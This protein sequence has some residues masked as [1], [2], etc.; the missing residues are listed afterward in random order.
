M[1]RNYILSKYMENSPDGEVKIDM[2]QVK[3]HQSYV[4][5]KPEALIA[6]DIF[7]AIE[8]LI[9]IQYTEGSIYALLQKDGKYKLRIAPELDMNP[10]PVIL[11][12][13]DTT[14][15]RYYY[16]VRSENPIRQTYYVSSIDDERVRYLVAEHIMNPEKGVSLIER[17]YHS[18]FQDKHKAERY[19]DIKR[20]GYSVAHG[21]SNS[22]FRVFVV[23]ANDMQKSK[24][25][26]DNLEIARQIKEYN[27]DAEDYRYIPNI[28]DIF[29]AIKADAYDSL[30]EAD[31][32]DI[33]KCIYQSLRDYLPEDDI[34][35][36]DEDIDCGDAKTVESVADQAII[37]AI[38]NAEDEETFNKIYKILGHNE[39]RV[40]ALTDDIYNA[41]PETGFILASKSGELQ[42][43]PEC[44]AI[45]DWEGAKD[46]P[47]YGKFQ[48]NENDTL[49]CLREFHPE[50]F[51]DSFPDE[52]EI[53]M[54]E[55]KYLEATVAVRMKHPEMKFDRDDEGEETVI[56]NWYYSGL[57]AKNV[58]NGISFHRTYGSHTFSAEECRKLLSGE[59]LVV[60][61]FI[62]KMDIETTI[63]GKLKDCAGLYDDEMNVEF[64][65]TDINI[66][67]NRR[68]LNMDMGIEEPGL[69]PAEG[70]VDPGGI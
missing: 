23:D 51:V 59:E 4:I 43:Y 55:R 31:Q 67:K 13:V 57:T 54:W 50:M 19:W 27:L 25:Y 1:T 29:V 53:Q 5:D 7:A 42:W 56:G 48:K 26:K 40:G 17:C 10:L 11:L 20:T 60:E 15:R 69:P 16:E 44:Y 3:E 8:D 35:F 65:R 49:Y 38:A 12:G 61:K 63:R 14:K 70:D 39:Y 62:T 58:I 18:C 45:N 41:N 30:T 9:D 32:I 68:M 6:Y 34:P 2:R 33:N 36:M 64:V 28:A 66:S 47:Y 22:G 21:L 37:L 52:D 46:N 24:W